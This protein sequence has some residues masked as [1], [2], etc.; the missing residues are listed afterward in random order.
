M[1]LFFVVNVEGPEYKRRVCENI[2]AGVVKTL[3]I[4]TLLQHVCMPTQVPITLKCNHNGFSCPNTLLS[5]AVSFVPLF[6]VCM[7]ASVYVCVC[8]CARACACVN[9]F[10]CV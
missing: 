1:I 9:A 2:C 3:G 7:H 6:F 8:V 4:K 10:V 5:N